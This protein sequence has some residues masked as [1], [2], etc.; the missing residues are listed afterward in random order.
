[1]KYS[2]MKITAFV[3]ISLTAFASC[4][5][6]PEEADY[7]EIEQ[8]ILDLWMAANVPEATRW[9]DGYYTQV[10]DEGDTSQTPIHEYAD[11]W[12]R[13]NLDGYDFDGNLI[14]TRNELLAYQ[15]GTFVDHIRYTPLF[16]DLY[17]NSDDYD[18]IY[19]SYDDP[20]V[21]DYLPE[22]LNLAFKNEVLNL[23]KGAKLILY[24]PSDMIDDADY[25]IEGFTGQYTLGYYSPMK[26]IVEIVDAVEDPYAV[27]VAAVEEFMNL[28][29]G[30]VIN[31]REGFNEDYDDD[32]EIDSDVLEAY[33][34]AQELIPE[35]W[36]NSL[37]TVRNVYLYRRFTFATPLTYVNP[38]TSDIPESVYNQYS[39][40][41][42]DAMLKEVIDDN[43]YE[44]K[45]TSKYI[46]FEGSAEVWYIGRFLDGFI[47]DTNISDVRDLVTD[48]GSAFNPGV[49]EWW[50]SEASNYITAWAYSI[51]Q[52][53]YGQW[54]TIITTSGNAYGEVTLDDNIPAYTP[55]IFHIYINPDDYEW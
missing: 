20:D 54:A 26:M 14:V 47:F 49:M 46:G 50:A 24:V 8:D 32:Y 41:E 6:E 33:N 2:F 27:E 52:L 4:V 17:F 18:D 35:N 37:D 10:L 15:M 7:D 34:N 22:C 5:M 44:G 13:Y 1:M 40:A 48:D 38:Y 28:N 3:V 43:F 31:Y 30:F 39:M 29:G 42:I 36:S 53:R 51:P 9:S 16:Q 11:C 23:H 19:S 21:Y 55:L 25:A 12:I 45:L